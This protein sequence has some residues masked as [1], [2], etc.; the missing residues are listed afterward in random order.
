MGYC[1]QGNY[2]DLERDAFWPKWVLCWVFK[3]ETIPSSYRD[4]TIVPL[5]PIS[6]VSNSEVG[7][8]GNLAANPVS[9]RFRVLQGLTFHFPFLPVS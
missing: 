4:G 7:G 8:R 5:G 9:P 2:P 6:G 3:G 1:L